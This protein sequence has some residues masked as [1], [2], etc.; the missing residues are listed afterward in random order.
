MS[1]F[2]RDMWDARPDSRPVNAPIASPQR[3]SGR[4]STATSGGRMA[5]EDLFI[6]AAKKFSPPQMI[7][8]LSRP[9]IRQ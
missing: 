1:V 3:S 7:V 6:S 5:V 4:P 9:T 2:C 8:S